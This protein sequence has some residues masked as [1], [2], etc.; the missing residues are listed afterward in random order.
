MVYKLFT[1]DQMKRH[2]TRIGHKINLKK[3][4]QNF[5][6]EFLEIAFSIPTIF[7]QLVRAVFSVS[8]KT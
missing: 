6:N 1:S 7:T 2:K 4:N 8:K 3:K 5:L